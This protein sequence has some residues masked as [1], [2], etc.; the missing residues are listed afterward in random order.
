MAPFTASR[1]QPPRNGCLRLRHR[2]DPFNQWQNGVVNGHMDHTGTPQVG[3]RCLTT[4]RIG[5]RNRASTSTVTQ[6]DPPEPGASRALTDRSG[7]GS[8]SP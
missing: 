8:T 4:R 5:G 7:P 2:P 6:I 1:D 3:A